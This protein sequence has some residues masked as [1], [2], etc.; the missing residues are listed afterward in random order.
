MDRQRLQDRLYYGLGIAAR[1][2]GDFTDAFRPTG[3]DHPLDKSNRFLRLP[4]SFLP[5]AGGATRANGYGT[6]LWQGLFDAA[7]TKPGDYLVQQDRTFLLPPSNHCCQFSAS[8]LIGR[9]PYRGQLYKRARQAIP[10]EAT[11]RPVR[12]S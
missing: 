11:Q 2:M 7:Y 9:S 1:R 4:A 6:A 3:P 10:T 12:P 8:R 5:M